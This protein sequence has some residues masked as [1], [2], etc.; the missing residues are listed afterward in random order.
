MQMV[1][2]LYLRRQW[3][4]DQGR[5]ARMVGLWASAYGSSY[6][7]TD[8][9]RSFQLLLFPEGTNLTPETRQDRKET[10]P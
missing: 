7:S 4:E 1:R 8:E 10:W 3:K 2:C 9:K 5:I 6:E